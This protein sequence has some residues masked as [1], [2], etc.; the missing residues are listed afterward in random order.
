MTREVVLP[1]FNASATRSTPQ[2]PTV[3]S[4][5]HHNRWVTQP[6][7]PSRSPARKKVPWGNR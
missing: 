7:T 3:S 5:A 1:I 4:S 6:G 2:K